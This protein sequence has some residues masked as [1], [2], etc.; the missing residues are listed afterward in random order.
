MPEFAVGPGVLASIAEHRDRAAT[1]EN[2]V[3]GDAW[4]HSITFGERGYQYVYLRA[5]GKVAVFPPE[6]PGDPIPPPVPEVT[7]VQVPSPN[8]FDGRD[9]HNP[10]AIVLHTMGGTLVGTDSWFKRPE[11][12]VSTH[13]GVGLDGKVHQYVA[14][15]DGAWGNGLLE[16]GNLWSG[17]PGALPGVN[18]NLLTCSIETEDKRPDGTWATSVTAAQLA[19]V[20]ALIKRIKAR[21]PNTIKYL[22]THRSISPKSRPGC[23]GKRWVDS[24]AMSALAMAAGLETRY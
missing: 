24:G 4:T 8:H 20:S 14:L 5:T 15:S 18:P 21:F 9:G 7:I 3:G 13:Y 6:N 10:I 11:S 17:L 1:N 12:Q 22:I 16:D 23:P 2:Y 19:S